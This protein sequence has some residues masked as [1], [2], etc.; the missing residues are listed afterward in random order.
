MP[1]MFT[2]PA[3]PLAIGTG[4]GKETVSGKLLVLGI[5]FSILPDFDVIAFKFGIPYSSQ[6]GHRGF[7]HSLFFAIVI[8]LAFAYLLSSKLALNR[9]RVFTF[10]FIA[11]ASHGL[12]DMFTDGGL[13]IALLW[14]F[15]NTRYFWPYQV[16]TVSPIGIGFFSDW[17]LRTLISEFFWIWLPSLF[18]A[19]FLFLGV[20]LYR[21]V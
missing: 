21:R 15:T 17:G 7:T 12:L 5:L 19:I 4:L 16:I 9:G 1:T 14:P 8:S 3:I 13:G 10:L 2:H 6:W 11:M 20:R 18:T